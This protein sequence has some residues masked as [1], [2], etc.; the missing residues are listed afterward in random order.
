MEAG[1]DFVM[2]QPF[3]DVD[4]LDKILDLVGDFQLPIL[5][6]ILPAA[7][8]PARRV[9]AQRGAGHHHPRLGAQAH[10]RRR[11]NGRQEGIAW[12]RS[13]CSTPTRK[14]PAPT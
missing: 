7:E 11:P 13:Y 1:A 4:L 14:W 9:P 5:M 6:G 8:R 10:A 12:P 2:T 3:F